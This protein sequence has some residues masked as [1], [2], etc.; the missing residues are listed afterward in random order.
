MLSSTANGNG[1]HVF[2]S[3]SVASFYSPFSGRA[4]LPNCV[5]FMGVEEKARKR[6]K[7]CGGLIGGLGAS[8][9]SRSTSN[10]RGTN[11]K[12]HKLCEFID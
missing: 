5:A 10:S 11:L 3:C 9:G 2:L 7:A 12:F 8:N 1:L 6:V 4:N